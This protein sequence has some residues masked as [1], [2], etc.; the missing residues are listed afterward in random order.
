V[1]FN[2]HDLAL[3]TR[4]LLETDLP[5]RYDSSESPRKVRMVSGGN[6][7]HD[8]HDPLYKYWY[9]LVEVYTKKD[10]SNTQDKLPAIL[11]LAQ[12]I[13]K[14]GMPYKIFSEC[15]KDGVWLSEPS[16]LLWYLEA[17]Y[18]GAIAQVQG[19]PTYSWGS[20][21]RSV[22]FF[23]SETVISGEAHL[24]RAANWEELGG[25]PTAQ[26]AVIGLPDETT[27]SIRVRQSNAFGIL[28]VH[29]QLDMGVMH[30]VTEKP[31]LRKRAGNPES[32]P[33]FELPSRVPWPLECSLSYQADWTRSAS[34]ILD[35]PRD[36]DVRK[37]L[38]QSQNTVW[39]LKLVTAQDVVTAQNPA[40]RPWRLHSNHSI[41]RDPSL[42]FDLG[43]VLIPSKEDLVALKATQEAL[44]VWN[45]PD[46]ISQAEFGHD[47]E[48]SST[49]PPMNAD[50]AKWMHATERLQAYKLLG[51]HNTTFRRVG[52]Y[53]S[54]ASAYQYYTDRVTT[55]LLG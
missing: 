38:E 55:V 54:R 49:P 13:H 34:V 32:M 12:A 10:L 51:P 20:W 39:L 16:S 5:S 48:R 17:S 28:Q 9:R 40:T 11:G 15:Y 4:S 45:P 18:E 7:D 35:N 3:N 50:P 25:S 24:F 2:S 19:N 33:E 47:W 8:S 30:I 43:L 23:L 41:E 22:K 53:R 46:A 29:G 1:K 21:N 26:T 36:P 14:S 31:D 37:W 44:D 6:D 27:S 42:Y 52:I